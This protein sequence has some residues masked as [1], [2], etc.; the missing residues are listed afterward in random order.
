M[1]YYENA[2]AL[3]KEMGISAS[4]LEQTMNDY[5]IVAEKMANGTPGAQYDAYGGGKSHDK[6]GKK[7]FHN[8]P[9]TVQ[10]EYN[11]AVVTPVIHY[12][13]GGLEIDTNSLVYGKNGQPIKGLYAAGE[14]A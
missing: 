3:A 1:K 4:T 14:I 12:C 13:M 8:W 7:F 9:L 6:F 5:N 10:D 11:V 2:T